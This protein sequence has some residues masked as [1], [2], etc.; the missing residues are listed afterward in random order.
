MILVVDKA[1]SDLD[2]ISRAFL[3]WAPVCVS[4]GCNSWVDLSPD[5]G[6]SV[7]FTPHG[8]LSTEKVLHLFF[9]VVIRWLEDGDLLPLRHLVI[10]V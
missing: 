2:P 10:S 9:I 7:E 6:F 3:F 1:L 5:V 4:K 8:D